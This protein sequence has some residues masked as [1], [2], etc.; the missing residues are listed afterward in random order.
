[1]TKQHFSFKEI[2]MFGWAKTQ[3]HAW[4]I[5]LTIIIMGIIMSAV[6]NVPLFGNLVSILVGLSVASISLTI[7]RDHHFTF[8]DLFTPFLSRNRVL[9]YVGL[10][11]LYAVPA[12]I[13]VTMMA[14]AMMM[15]NS[16][17]AVVAAILLL[18]AIYIAI[19][20]M[21]FSFVAIDHEN[22]KFI[23]LIKLS[24]R[25]TS[26][27]FVSVFIFFVLIVILNILGSLVFVIG[28][29]VTVPVSM[30]ATARLYNQ[31]KD[32]HAE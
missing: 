19:R 26:A 1:M 16:S 29:F 4:F 11:L 23:E 3:Q 18:L 5:A 17:T 20:F 2:F 31:I 22:A 7:S 32:H 25:L 6:S 28:L 13:A 10:S 14:T 27:N 24:Y 8:A 21:F 12:M 15:R 9:K 30:F